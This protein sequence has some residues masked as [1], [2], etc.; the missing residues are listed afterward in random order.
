M[1]ASVAVA[2][3]LPIPLHS[4]ANFKVSERI[5]RGIVKRRSVCIK[6]ET[7]HKMKSS[8]KVCKSL[9]IARSGS[10]L[11]IL[12]TL[13]LKTW[14]LQLKAWTFQMKTLFDCFKRSP[15]CRYKVSFG[16]SLWGRWY[17]LPQAFKPL[18]NKCFVNFPGILKAFSLLR[19]CVTLVVRQPAGTNSAQRC[20]YREQHFNKFSVSVAFIFAIYFYQR[21]E[22]RRTLT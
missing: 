21:R 15:T 2:V 13:Q 22:I 4:R 16:S 20:A 12:W 6:T 11:L 19:I 5:A 1:A 9:L 7:R 18:T 14:T 8:G 3:K 10:F 17:R